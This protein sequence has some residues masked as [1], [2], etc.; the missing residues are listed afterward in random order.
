[1]KINRLIYFTDISPLNFVRRLTKLPIDLSLPAEYM[2]LDAQ[3]V[4][5]GL[6]HS[7]LLELYYLTL[8]P[9]DGFLPLGVDR[10]NGEL[11]AASSVRLIDG[12]CEPFPYFLPAQ[13]VSNV[14]PHILPEPKPIDSR[15]WLVNREHAIKKVER[16][17]K[18]VA[19][20]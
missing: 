12:K 14:G 16:I 11:V 7:R 19:S 3:V 6:R 8:H 17:A 20:K 1:M 4:A 2:L 15:T 9:H 13:N 5:V 10:H 18:R